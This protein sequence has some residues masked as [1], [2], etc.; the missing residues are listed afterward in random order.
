[1]LGSNNTWFLAETNYDHWK[2]PLF[3]D[4]RITPAN[5]CMNK[6]GQSVG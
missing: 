6:L 5:N 4:D 1:M 3:V 2:A